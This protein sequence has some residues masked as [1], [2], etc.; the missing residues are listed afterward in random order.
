M[1]T[2]HISGNFRTHETLLTLGYVS[3]R[4]SQFTGHTKAVTA[5]QLHPQNGLAVSASLDGTLRVLN[6]EGLEEIYALQIMQ[7]LTAMKCV[8]LE[9]QS[10]CIGATV[11]GTIRVWSI[12]N[13]L[14]FFGV[15]RAACESAVSVYDTDGSMNAVCIAGEDIRI[16][17]ETG[18]E[19]GAGGEE[20]IDDASARMEPC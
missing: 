19:K 20:R 18:G 2:A 9:D 11:D 13:F 8:Y 7:P 16:F 6:L 3:L 10:F 17:S 14:G 15:C 5:L 1:R 4:S 12:N